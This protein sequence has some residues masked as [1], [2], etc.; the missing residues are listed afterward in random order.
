MKEA[1]CLPAC[2]LACL[3]ALRL[4]PRG[5]SVWKLI[6]RRL[7]LLFLFSYGPKKYMRLVVTDNGLA[8]EEKASEIGK[9]ISLPWVIFAARK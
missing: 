5:H 4:V 6:G 9:G 1:H 8:M 3:P 7:F 2:L